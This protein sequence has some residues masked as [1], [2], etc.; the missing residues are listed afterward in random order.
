MLLDLAAY[1]PCI[2]QQFLYI[3]FCF[4]LIELTIFIFIIITSIFFAGF[5]FTNIIG[6]SFFFCWAV[7]YKWMWAIFY[8]ILQF[9]G[10]F[11]GQISFCFFRMQR[12]FLSR[13]ECL[14]FNL[15]NIHQL[16]EVSYFVKNHIILQ[17]ICMVLSY[18][19]EAGRK[20]I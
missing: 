14:G 7:N 5:L 11:A 1:I 19:M 16:R 9:C 10:D 2:Y 8:I 4:S 17:G 15:R 13:V 12:N 6:F 3:N 18:K 20:K